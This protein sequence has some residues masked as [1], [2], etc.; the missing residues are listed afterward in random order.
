MTGVETG[1]FLFHLRAYNDVDHQI[2]VIHRLLELGY[3]VRILFVD[4]YDFVS[5]YR[6][7]PILDSPN[8]SIVVVSRWSK[9]RHRLLFGSLALRYLP[10]FILKSFRKILP[11]PGYLKGVICA[12]YDW[13][14]TARLN[15][16][17]ARQN[18]I[19]TV[20]IPHGYNSFRNFDF[21]VTL[22]EEA[23]QGRKPDFTQRELFDRYVLNSRQEQILMEHWGMSSRSTVVLGSPRFSAS[24][25]KRN[26]EMLK[27]YQAPTS[28]TK[29]EEGLTVLL[30]LPHW[31]YRV[32][33]EETL[34]TVKA[35]L[36]ET[37]VSIVIRAHTR[38]SE[39]SLDEADFTKL[40]GL[41]GRLFYDDSTPTSVLIKQS[42]LVLSFGTSIVIEAL[43]VGKPVF[44]LDYLDENE[45]I[46][47][48]SSGVR[49]FNNRNELTLAVKQSEN[50][51]EPEP[52]M[53]AEWQMSF[54]YGDKRPHDVASSYCRE[55]LSLVSA[56]DSEGL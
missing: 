7:Q 29:C 39:G 41:N 12:V 10:D 19:P 52:H 31:D 33:R 37:S 43:I 56:C 49:S 2:P 22:A 21:S 5:D 50:Y 45:T 26:L 54:I 51:P 3:R 38:G 32:R 6:F 55:L 53:S 8:L 1:V 20:A 47:D 34:E 30:L 42:N 4:S 40:G 46:F 44:A 13:G 27:N 25:I 16:E 36:R 18:G 48:P 24:W 15:F 9:A 23:K 28:A 17:E 35:L 11:D 14:T